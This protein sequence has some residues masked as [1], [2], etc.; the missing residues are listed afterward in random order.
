MHVNFC[1]PSFRRTPHP[2]IVTIRDNKDYMR[3]LF[4]SY[5]TA[6]T[7]WGVLLT[8]RCIRTSEEPPLLIRR[9]LDEETRV[10]A[11]LRR[12]P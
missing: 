5:Y 2:A 9:A 8:H 4:Y 6:I 10:G 12:V 1:Y 7:A 11:G 3:V